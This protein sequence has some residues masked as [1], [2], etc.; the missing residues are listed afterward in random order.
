MLDTNTIPKENWDFPIK[1]VPVFYNGYD[2]LQREATTHR[3]IIREDT[4]QM[5]GLHSTRYKPITH[6]DVVN[7]MMD[8]VKESHI[9]RDYDLKVDVYEDG[10]KMKGTIM[11]PDLVIEPEKNDYISFRVQFY[12]SYDGSWAFQQAADGLRLWCL[13]GCTTPDSVARTFAKHTTNVNVQGSGKKI[14]AGADTFINN[15]YLF[16]KFIDTPIDIDT[17]ENFI[18]R[19]LCHIP[20]KRGKSSTNQARFTEL[21]NYNRKERRSLGPNV[22]A[23]Y[24]AMTY[25]GSHAGNSKSPATALLARNNVIAKSMKSDTWREISNA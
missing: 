20:H 22:W 2:G 3:A 18:E 12:N 14:M 6:D 24:N 23:L 1:Q 25:W 17:A 7:S 9:S 21:S 13:N 5:L 10:R 8:A 15:R 16:Q 4:N 19:T 11:F